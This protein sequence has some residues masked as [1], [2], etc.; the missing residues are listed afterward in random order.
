MI[1]ITGSELPHFSFY[2][3]LALIYVCYLVDCLK[4]VGYQPAP[5]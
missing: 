1:Q 4:C 5:E 3:Y 2:R